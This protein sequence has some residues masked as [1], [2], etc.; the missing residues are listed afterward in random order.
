MSSK[1]WRSLVKTRPLGHIK[2]KLKIAKTY[3]KKKNEISE[4]G[5]QHKQGPNIRTNKIITRC[6]KTNSKTV[7]WI[8]ILI[9]GLFQGRSKSNFQ[10][11]LRNTVTF[12]R[13]RYLICLSEK[14]KKF[15]DKETLLLTSTSQTWKPMDILI[16]TW[17]SACGSVSQNCV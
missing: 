17:M 1:G 9:E 12:G 4:I 5:L 6:K 14:I 11:I 13:I 7:L 16:I 2:N 3:S 10:K 8:G 15:G